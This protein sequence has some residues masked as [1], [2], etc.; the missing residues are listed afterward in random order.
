MAL[1]RSPVVNPLGRG[2]RTEY[3]VS[4]EST[5]YRQGK[6]SLLHLPEIV[7]ASLTKLIIFFT[8]VSL[9]HRLA[10][11]SSS[12]FFTSA[13][14][15]RYIFYVFGGRSELGTTTGTGNEK[16]PI[17]LPGEWTVNLI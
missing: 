6:V 11:K 15:E 17:P 5:G 14:R 12:D 1:N 4:K 16:R 3:I 10:N 2:L 13:K 8:L 9:Y 7:S